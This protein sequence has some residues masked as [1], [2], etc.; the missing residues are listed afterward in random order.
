MMKNLLIPATALVCFTASTT[1]HAEVE[2]ALANICAIVEAD[3]KGEL[4][5]KM[6]KVQSNYSLRLKDYYDGITCGGNSLIRVAVL[7]DAVD[8]GTLLVKKMPKKLLSEPESD[9]KTILAWISE[10]GQS[11]S[12]IA[13]EVKDRM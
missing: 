1:A 6:R 4:R 12:L 11:N 13:Q 9:G 3:D 10:Q 7:A 5:K 8:T 2:E